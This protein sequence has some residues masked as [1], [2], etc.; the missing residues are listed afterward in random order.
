MATQKSKPRTFFL[1]EQHE[2]ARK[3][4]GGGGAIPQYVGINWASRGRRISRSLTATEQKIKQSEDPLRDQRLYFMAIP[5]AELTKSSTQKKKAP[6]GTFDEETDFA[7]EHGRVF[8]RLGLDLIEVTDAGQAIVHAR[9]ERF[10]QLNSLSDRLGKLGPREQARWATVD[11]FEIIPPSLRVDGEWLNSLSRTEPADAV[12]ELQPLLNRV[13]IETVMRALAAQLNRASSERLTGT[14]TDIS[15]RQWVRGRVSEKSLRGIAQKFFSVQSIHPPLY[16]LAA[17]ARAH[18]GKPIKTAPLH[19]PPGL[20]QELPTIALVDT[21]TPA[22]HPLLRDY[23][24]GQYVAPDVT[25]GPGTHG[26]L[27][28]SRLV[29]GEADLSE[30]LESVRDIKGDC[31][32][33]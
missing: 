14:G 16:S 8:G 7:K 10:E 18:A 1:N 22:G 23:R 9:P 12:I 19:V 24:R 31:L 4:Q 5:V 32:A 20:R 29:F 25:S 26:A 6:K 28:A 17:Q 30:G 33:L 21:G 13:E 2:L 27:V 11:S 15:G 3:K